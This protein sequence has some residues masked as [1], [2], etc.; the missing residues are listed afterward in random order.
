MPFR[1]PQALFKKL[2]DPEAGFAVW[3]SL[4][5]VLER[6]LV[7]LQANLAKRPLHRG[8]KRGAAA[9]LIH[10]TRKARGV[11]VRME[12]G[13]APRPSEAPAIRG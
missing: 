2:G 13:Q 5:D 7:A 11:W 9:L 12:G 8:S 6:S 1:A 10:P 3:A 4:S